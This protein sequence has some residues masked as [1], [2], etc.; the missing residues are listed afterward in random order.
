AIH[1]EAAG[2]SREA[3]D[4]NRDGER[5]RD[6][7]VALAEPGRERVPEHTPGVTQRRAPSA[8]APRR[9]RC[10]ICCEARSFPLFSSC[11]KSACIRSALIT[12]G[13]LRHPR[14]SLHIPRGFF[15]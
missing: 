12:R 6:L 1:P 10:S 13:S 4:K 7:G 5:Q 14:L 2:K 8:S 11:A 9:Q 3:E 15:G